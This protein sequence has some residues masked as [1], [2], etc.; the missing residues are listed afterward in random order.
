MR[1]LDDSIRRVMQIYQIGMRD[2][3]YMAFDLTLGICV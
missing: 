1:T 3:V 2:A